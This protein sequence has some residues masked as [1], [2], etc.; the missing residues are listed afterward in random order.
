MEDPSSSTTSQIRFRDPRQDQADFQ[1]IKPRIQL[2]PLSRGGFVAGNGE[3]SGVLRLLHITHL[4]VPET[5][6]DVRNIIFAINLF[7]LAFRRT[8]CPKLLMLFHRLRM[9]TVTIRFP[10]TLFT[11]GVSPKFSCRQKADNCTDLSDFE[12]SNRHNIDNTGLV[13]QWPSE[14]ALAYFCLSQCD[15][16]RGKRVIELGAGYGLAGLVIAAATEAS[17]VVISDGN[18]QVV[19]YIERNIKSNSNTFGS[20]SVKAMELHWNQEDLSDLTGAFDIIVASDCTF[21]KEFHEHLA[22][23]VKMLLKAKEPS[24]ALF[25]SPKRGDSLGKFLAEIEDTGLNFS[26]TENYDSE[27]WKRHQVLMNGDG[28]WPS[29]EQNHS[30]PLLV[31]ITNPN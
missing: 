22:R 7:L 13:C 6:S 25:F 18:P 26:L 1:K 30:Y 4:R 21:F 8:Q 15:L 14:E 28:S 5:P 24:Q 9:R 23:I 27:V 29:Y 31:R 3:F 12:I 10:R 16:F 19:N 2:D 20:T 11:F 17:E